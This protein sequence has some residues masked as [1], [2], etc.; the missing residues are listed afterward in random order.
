MV[1]LRNDQAVGEG[2]SWSAVALRAAQPAGVQRRHQAVG[3][4]LVLPCQRE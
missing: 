1:V 4:G 2:A 3:L